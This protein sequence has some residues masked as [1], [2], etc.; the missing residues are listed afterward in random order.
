MLAT[1]GNRAQRIK[2]YEAVRYKTY[3]RVGQIQRLKHYRAVRYKTY[4][5]LKLQKNRKLEDTKIP[6]IIMLIIIVGFF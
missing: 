3:S 1:S 6:V 5:H 4:T 2:H